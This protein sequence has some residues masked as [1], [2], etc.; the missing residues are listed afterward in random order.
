MEETTRIEIIDHG[1]M[2]SDYYSGTAGVM[3]PISLD[4][5][6]TIGEIIEKIEEEINLVWDHIE[7]TAEGH[8]FVGCLETSILAEILKIKEENTGK[9]D[10]IHAPNLDFNFY[11]LEES[12]LDCNE[13]PVLI[14]SIEFLEE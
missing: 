2:L 9:L 3:L 12:E 1:I 4:N 7:Y 6:T 11:E 14:L 13:F 8:N 5:T 10:K